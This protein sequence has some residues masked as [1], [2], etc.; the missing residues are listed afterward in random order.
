MITDNE[1]HFVE[2]T[3]DGIMSGKVKYDVEFFVSTKTGD[4]F[5]STMKTIA[6]WMG[7]RINQESDKFK[8]L[9]H[10]LFAEFVSS[11]ASQVL[12]GEVT[13]DGL[14]KELQTLH[15]ENALMKEELQELI[16]KHIK[17]EG[18]NKKL[19]DENIALANELED[20]KNIVNS[21]ENASLK[22]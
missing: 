13:D 10:V 4:K 15:R 16:A 18:E 6:E 22:K 8:E 20:L 19:H 12:Q 2:L 3:V 21:Y 7:E 5:Q 17:A 1:K 9:T 14:E 11:R